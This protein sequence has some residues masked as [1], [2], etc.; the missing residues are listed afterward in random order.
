LSFSSLRDDALD[1]DLP[2]PYRQSHSRSCVMR[3]FQTYRLNRSEVV[4]LVRRVCG[5]DLTVPATEV[6]MVAALQ[7]LDRIKAAGL[8]LGGE[9]DAEPAAAADGGC[10]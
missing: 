4:D 10:G 2:L 3:I 5:T 8:T 7:A 6:Q 1:S 9:A